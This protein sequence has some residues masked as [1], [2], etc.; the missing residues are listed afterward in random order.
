MAA[1]RLERLVP[2]G[3]LHP[4][5]LIMT[6]QQKPTN[7]CKN[8]RQQTFRILRFDDKLS[9]RW[10]LRQLMPEPSILPL[11]VAPRGLLRRG[12]CRIAGGESV[13][14]SRELG[15]ADRLHRGE[16]GIEAAGK[17]RFYLLHRTALHH[18]GKPRK[19]G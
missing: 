10:A 6:G 5:H 2:R 15:Y 1:A 13:N 9:H 7:K 3:K 12:E 19:I 18:R 4:R 8:F 17:E 16:R 11:R 14:I